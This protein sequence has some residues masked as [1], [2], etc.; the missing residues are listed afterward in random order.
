MRFFSKFTIICNACFLLAVVAW[1]LET[2]QFHTGKNDQ[3]MPLPWLEGILVIIGYSAIFINLFYLMVCGILYL[4]KKAQQISRWM[5]IFNAIVFLL[6]VYFHFF[7][8]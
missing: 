2:Q 5:V 6:Q 7:L 1:Y 3:L 4:F 8:K